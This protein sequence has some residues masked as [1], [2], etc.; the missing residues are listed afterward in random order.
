MT[1][2]TDFDAPTLRAANNPKFYAR[3]KWLGLAAFGWMLWCLYDGFVGYPQ[4]RERAEKYLELLQE[5]WEGV[6]TENGWSESGKSPLEWAAIAKKNGWTPSKIKKVAPAE[7]TELAKSNKWPVEKPGAPKSDGDVLSQFVMAGISA[8]AGAWMVGTVVRTNSRWI[9]AGPT[10]V[11]SSWGETVPFERV[12]SID[13]RQWT[14]KG[15]ARVY[16]DENGTQRKFVID[17]YKFDR[18]ATDEIL[19]RVE[20]NAGADK[21]TNGAP[22]P[23]R[24]ETVEGQGAEGLAAVD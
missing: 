5:E 10:G 19:R 1:P 23:P 20:E 16:Y 14:D 11:T 12:T 6:A 3:F 8:L 7:W 17:D 18:Y 9:E 22:M 21:I 15:I 24:G 4:Q 13:K 2:S